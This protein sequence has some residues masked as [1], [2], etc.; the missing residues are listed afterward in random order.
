[1]LTSKIL[2][3]YSVCIGNNTYLYETEGKL[4]NYIIVAE[5]SKNE[6]FILP[7]RKYEIIGTLESLG[8]SS[9]FELKRF[10]VI[11]VKNNI[12]ITSNYLH[13]FD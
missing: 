9:E 2:K 3:I 1:M 12:N 11:D 6:I 10:K 8:Y 5:N 13:I 7:V 4:R